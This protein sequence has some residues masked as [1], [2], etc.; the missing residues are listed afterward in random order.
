MTAGTI[1]ANSQQRLPHDVEEIG[2]QSKECDEEQ[3]QVSIGIVIQPRPITLLTGR[4]LMKSTEPER[5]LT[6]RLSLRIPLRLRV[7]Q[8][9]GPEETAESVDLSERGVLLKT[10]VALRV[11][12]ELELHLKIPEET[13]GVPKIEWRCTGRVVHIVRNIPSSGPVTAGVHFGRLQ[14][15][16][17]SNCS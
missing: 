5:R 12:M 3:R 2:T 8:S 13:S 14:I 11:G 10:E 6:R 9:F 15:L 1:P 17:T 16:R 4:G 7:C